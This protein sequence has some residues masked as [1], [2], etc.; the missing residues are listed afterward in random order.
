MNNFWKDLPRPFFALA[1]M[2]DV[3]D[4]AFRALIAKY[5]STDTPRVFYTEFTS[6]DGLVRADPDGQI[7]LRKKLEFGDLE[8]PIVAQ[9]FS[10]TPEYME[11]ATRI[12][13]EVGFDGVDINMGC[14]DRAVE[15]QGSGAVLIKSPRRA[16]ELIRA[17]RAGAGSIPVSVKTRVGYAQEEIDTWI[18]SILDEKPAALAVHLRTRKELSEVPAHWEWMSR[19]V[20][21]RDSISPE[22]RLMGNGDVVN[23]A[24]ARMK[25]ESTGV[26]GIM[27]GRAVFGN[28]WLFNEEDA[29]TKS[30]QEKVEALIEH[31]NLFR[32]KL[33][34]VV[35]EAVMKRHFKAYINGWRG[36]AELRARLMET[37]DLSE[38]LAV[39]H[40]LDIYSHIGA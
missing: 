17:A 13:R 40:S 30:P 29:H 3:T 26:D 10:S 32:E 34:G 28:P 18:A 15:K 6:A 38:A 9:L 33:S 12:V 25:A 24:D 8:R 21:L 39:L 16:K 20:A 7:R 22:T 31:I 19:I 4:A 27:L 5:A 11:R 37:K 14:P 36:A 23:I 1:P 2:E 35:S